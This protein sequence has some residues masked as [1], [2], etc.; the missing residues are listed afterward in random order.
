M[1]EADQCHKHCKQILERTVIVL[2]EIGK[3]KEELQKQVSEERYE[4]EEFRSQVNALLRD[5]ERLERTI[6]DLKDQLQRLQIQLQNERTER[7]WNERLINWQVEGY[8]RWY[9]GLISQLTNDMG[10]NIYEDSPTAPPPPYTETPPPEEQPIATDTN[11]PESP[12]VG[13]C[14]LPAS[15]PTYTHTGIPES[16]FR[17]SCHPIPVG[18][19]GLGGFV[20]EEHTEVTTT[21]TTRSRRVYQ[22]YPPSPPELRLANQVSAGCS[23]P[24]RRQLV[25]DYGLPSVSSARRNRTC[26]SPALGGRAAAQAVRRQDRAFSCPDGVVQPLGD[27]GGV[28]A[29]FAIG[30]AAPEED[31]QELE[32][33]LE[34]NDVQRIEEQEPR[35]N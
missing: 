4:K 29:D 6:N 23:R 8:R 19:S 22:H 16:A 11:Q 34:S 35:E 24:F 9:E 18:E 13:A 3:E 17:R 32:S 31:H 10:R 26:S 7:V 21:T 15:I 27:E 2:D 30:E 33:A 14:A 1:K 20:V 28:R 12:L 5:Q 25:S